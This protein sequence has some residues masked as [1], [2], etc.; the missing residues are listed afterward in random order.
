MAKVYAIIS[1][2]GGVGKT[3]FV[4]NL[5]YEMARR[6]QRVLIIDT[7]FGQ[8]NIDVMLGMSAK[9]TIEQIMTGEKKLT[10]VLIQGPEGMF[11]LPSTSGLTNLTDLPPEKKMLI[12]SELEILEDCFDIV[13]IDTGAGIHDNVLYFCSAAHEVILIVMPQLTSL[14]DAA[15]LVLNANVKYKESKFN[16]VIN[17]ADSIEEG[18]HFSRKFIRFIDTVSLKKDI[19]VLVKPIGYILRDKQVEHSIIQQKPIM[20]LYPTAVASK[21]ITL[22]TDKILQSKKIMQPKGSMQ[23]FLRK[24]LTEG[25]A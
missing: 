2:K 21:C 11:I 18:K 7:D 23:F 15:S 8:A 6:G 4:V 25:A 9:Y 16:L 19:N 24:F 20:S 13:L 5:A 22:L 17:M 12:L 14:K 10:D 3:F 1:G